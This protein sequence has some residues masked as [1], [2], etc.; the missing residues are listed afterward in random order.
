MTN[1]PVS[2]FSYVGHGLSLITKPGIKRFVVIPLLINIAVFSTLSWYGYQQFDL[3]MERLLPAE[4]WLSFLRWLLW[5][6]FAVATILVAFSTF[7]IIANLIAS[8]F[9][10]LLAERVEL[11]LTGKT[12]DQ[13]TNWLDLV[14]SIIP[15]IFTELRK[16]LYYLSRAIPLLILFI[17][18][19]VNVAAPF[20]WF[21]FSAWFLT[22]T[23]I[24]FPMGNHQ[25]GFQTQKQDMGKR[26]VLSL[27]FGTGLTLMT[28]IPILNFI[29]MPT[30]VAGATKIWVDELQNS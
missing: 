23:Y 24:D 1:N 20:L 7:T 18:P 2:G 12:F 9:N 22:L 5:P 30:G 8:P 16:I 19:V 27:S 4:S 29:A 3:F 14:K 11:Y 17:I 26:R 6:L 13:E 25:I 10:S 28:M 15:T 21:L